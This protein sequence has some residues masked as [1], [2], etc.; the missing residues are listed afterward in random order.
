M[1]F[2]IELFN[3]KKEEVVEEEEEELEIFRAPQ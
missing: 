3:K 2:A 1:L